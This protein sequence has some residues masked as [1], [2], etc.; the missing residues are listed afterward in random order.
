M[1][2]PAARE[3][4]GAADH[5]GEGKESALM[6]HRVWTILLLILVVGF[7]SHCHGLQ[8]TRRCVFPTGDTM[9]SVAERALPDWMRRRDP[10][11]SRSRFV[12]VQTGF[13]P[14]DLFHYF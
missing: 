5:V 13:Q 8:K 11:R 4:L 7:F 9:P 3:A 2:P 1:V 12:F 14:G 10:L 6:Y